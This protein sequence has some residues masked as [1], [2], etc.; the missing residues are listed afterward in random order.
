MSVSQRVQ[1][2]GPVRT[3]R[4]RVARALCAIWFAIAA[5]AA[6]Q[7][8]NEGAQ[9][10]DHAELRGTLSCHGARDCAGA[11]VYIERIPGRTY[12]PGPEAVVDQ[13]QLTFL[14]H[15]L[16]VVTGTSVLFRNSDDVWHNVFS[17]SSS[18]RFNLGTYPRGVDKRLTMNKAGIVEVLCNVH[19]EMSAFIVVADTPFAVLVPRDGRYQ[20]GGLP[21]GTFDIVAWHETLRAQKRSVVL[22]AGDSQTVDFALGR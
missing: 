7:S 4:R 1:P 8:A 2:T 11:V 15:V 14:P 17:T 18:K 13:S 19:P 12:P 9:G 6:P 10:A 16:T 3:P 20:I 22:R 21:D 5:V